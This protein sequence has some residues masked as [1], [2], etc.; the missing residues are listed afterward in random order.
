MS[1]AP[2]RIFNIP[3]VA[4][5]DMN[6]RVVDALASCLTHIHPNVVTI[7]LKLFLQPFSLLPDQVHASRHFLWR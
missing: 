7:R 5:N 1:D 3:L 6:M 4:G 2:L